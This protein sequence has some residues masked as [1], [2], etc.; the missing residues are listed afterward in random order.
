MSVSSTSLSAVPFC[1]VYDEILRKTHAPPPL[2]PP[3]PPPPP[4]PTILYPASFLIKEA[5]FQPEVFVS[6]SGNLS[7]RATLSRLW[8]WAPLLKD[9]GA[10]IV[11][12]RDSSTNINSSAGMRG[13]G[14][15]AG[16]G[17]G[18]DLLMDDRPPS[19]PPPTRDIRNKGLFYWTSK[20][21]QT[22]TALVLKIKTICFPR[23]TAIFDH[24]LLFLFNKV[25]HFIT[26]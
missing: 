24:L 25:C 9:G 5:G 19:S 3:L 16:G 20:H 4:H 12:G 10:P 21:H 23:T 26:T 13:G 1:R 18:G 17:G 2:P 6:V 15:A 14:R 22:A 11:W 8:G 7:R